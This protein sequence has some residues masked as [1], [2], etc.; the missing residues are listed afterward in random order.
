MLDGVAF[1]LVPAN[2]AEPFLVNSPAS[3]NGTNLEIHAHTIGAGRSPS[4][5]LGNVAARLRFYEMR[6]EP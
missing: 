4:L 2:A 6:V 3:V 5:G 1:R